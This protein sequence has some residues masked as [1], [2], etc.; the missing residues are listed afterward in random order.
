M[1]ENSPAGSQTGHE[2]IFVKG[3]RIP[4]FP[5]LMS[6]RMLEVLRSGRYEESEATQLDRII[7]PGEVILEIGAG[8]G[9]ISSIAAR[10]PNT[11]RI[12][13]FEANPDLKPVIETVHRI[14]QIE[15]AVINTGVLMDRPSEDAVPFYIMQNFWGSSLCYKPQAIRQVLVPTID[16]NSALERIRP[17][18]IICDIEGGEL[19]LFE[20]ANLDGVTKIFME[21]HQ[22][23]LGRAGMKR[24]FDNLSAK[25]FH[26]DQNHSSGSVVLFSHI[27][28]PEA[29]TGRPPSPKSKRPSDPAKA[30]D[31]SAPSPMNRKPQGE[32]R[33]SPH[34]KTLSIHIG[35]HETCSHRIH[36]ILAGS[37]EELASQGTAYFDLGASVRKSANQ[38]QSAKAKP[39]PLQIE[40]L[41]K[42]IRDFEFSN[43]TE[44]MDRIVV[45][46]ENLSGW[47]PAVFRN[48]CYG[49]LRK[50]MV[51]LHQVLGEN[52]SISFTIRNTAEFFVAA[53]WS[54]I[55]AKGF[56]PFDDFVQNSGAL[57]FSWQSVVGDLNAVFGEG[58][59]EVFEFGTLLADTAAVVNRIAGSASVAAVGDWDEPYRPTRK[60]VQF[61]SLEQQWKSSLKAA[62][63]AQMAKNHFP[64]G[65]G[66]QVF[67]PWS[68]EHL[69]RLEENYQN[70]LKEI[71]T[72]TPVRV[73]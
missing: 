35:A 34:S 57:D 12:E 41:A 61:V 17:T 65:G 50:R 28:Y 13:V 22:R 1:L 30:A 70:D 53:Y 31:I 32:L 24:L 73:S 71:H 14:N 6:P 27:S 11:T 48:G 10:N 8:I 15:N 64:T 72:W 66:H 54:F 45:C 58:K 7:E 69:S 21:T 59:V 63:V 44:G 37:R 5:E 62:E 55:S 9:F 56:L 16:L 19:D 25:G 67:A 60:A 52:A 23:V 4:V 51:S 26:Y 2:T 40:Y 36:R 47:G 33:A 68:S 42:I 20:N 49:K 3:I 18:M 39:S 43:E 38:L 46:S 29:S